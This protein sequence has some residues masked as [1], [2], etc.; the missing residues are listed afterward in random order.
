MG[1]FVLRIVIAML[2][3]IFQM[4]SSDPLAISDIHHCDRRRLRSITS[5]LRESRRDAR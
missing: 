1:L 4:N 2:L 5:L 3:P